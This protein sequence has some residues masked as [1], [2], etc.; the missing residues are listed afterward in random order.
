MRWPKTQPG[1]ISPGYR[2]TLRWILH[3]RQELRGNPVR[4]RLVSEG[5]SEARPSAWKGLEERD[6]TGQV[7]VRTAQC[8]AARRIVARLASTIPGRR[9]DSPHRKSRGIVRTIFSEASQGTTTLPCWALPDHQKLA[10]SIEAKADE[11]F[12]DQDVGEYYDSPLN[13]SASNIR[14]GLMVSVAPSFNTDLRHVSR[15][16][17]TRRNNPAPTSPFSSSMNSL[18]VG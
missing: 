2:W 13:R 12:G 15:Q 5:A 8:R 7:Q 10:I 17:S 14:R 1:Q 16:P 9:G 18:Q 3:F 4:R 11:P 6:G